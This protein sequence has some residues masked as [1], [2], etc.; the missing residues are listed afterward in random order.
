M[1]EK[2]G[3]VKKLQ[4]SVLNFICVVFVCLFITQDLCI[5]RSWKNPLIFFHLEEYKS[6]YYDGYS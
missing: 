3:V 5:T 1:D 4:N 6:L 2:S